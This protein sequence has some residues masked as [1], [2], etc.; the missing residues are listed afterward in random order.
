MAIRT[1]F[2]RCAKGREAQSIDAWYLILGEGQ[3]CRVQHLWSHCE[4]ADHPSS[5]SENYTAAQLMATVDDSTVLACFQAALD[6]SVAT[7]H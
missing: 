1:L 7:R 4:E 3:E 5:G 6:H 2:Y